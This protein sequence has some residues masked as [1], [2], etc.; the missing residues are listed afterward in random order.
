MTIL[1]DEPQETIGRWDALRVRTVDGELL[2]IAVASVSAAGQV[3]VWYAPDPLLR[4]WLGRLQKRDDRRWV[5]RM[6]PYHV[7]ILDS[8]PMKPAGE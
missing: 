3:L 4:H 5:L 7:D 1:F 6:E 2:D 8:I